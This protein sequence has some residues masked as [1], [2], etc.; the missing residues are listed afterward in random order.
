MSKKKSS[1]SKGR[2]R[3]RLVRGVKRQAKKQWKLLTEEVKTGTQGARQKVSTKVGGKLDQADSWWDRRATA[4]QQLVQART[5]GTKGSFLA[6]HPRL[7]DLRDW[8]AMKGHGWMDGRELR[9]GIITQEEF[10]QFENFDGPEEWLAEMKRQRMERLRV[11]R[12]RNRDTDY[13]P[14][15]ITYGGNQTVGIPVVQ[16]SGFRPPAARP[17][18]NLK[19]VAAWTPPQ[20]RRTR[21]QRKN[22]I[23]N[24]VQMW[25]PQLRKNARTAMAG[26]SSM[27]GAIQAMNAFAEDFPET[28]TQVHEKMG[29]L[30]EFG[31]ANGEFYEN[32]V[33]TLRAGVN[34]DNPGLPPEVLQHL[35][36]LTE[37]G[38]QIRA[39]AEK[40][41]AAWE[42]YFAA[43]IAAAK[44]EHTP[45]KAALTS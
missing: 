13:G 7:G 4:K 19:P 32:L 18:P 34:E 40:T 33:S 31:N 11:Q 45:S 9:G 22:R 42:D 16:H 8:F 35:E 6:R 39:A 30:A 12:A 15:V 10:E 2:V 23:D 17:S 14:L 37:I 5:S 27:T 44:D 20:N 3:R 1:W 43:A 36:Q 41:L 28:R 21:R 38:D 26:N 29:V 24:V 25:G